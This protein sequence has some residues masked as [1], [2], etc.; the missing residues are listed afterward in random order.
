MSDKKLI[1]GQVLIA[2]PFMADPHF[3]KAVLALCDYSPKEGAVGFILNRPTNLTM[4]EVM[5]D[6]PEF[7]SHI[8]YGGPVANDTIHYIHRVGDLLEDSR[9]I[10]KG[11]YWGGDFTKL[12]FLISNKLIKPFD[13]KFY[14]GYSGWT[15]GQLEEEIEINS[16]VIGEMDI[17]YPFLNNSVDMWQTCLHHK[18]NNFSVLADM[19]DT[20]SLN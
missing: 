8:Y 10:I 20:I 1:Q 16:W 3:K 19:A 18:G 12:K 13:I 15:P 14:I 5:V 11:L 2:E 4:E 6:F 9:E 7:E 17:N